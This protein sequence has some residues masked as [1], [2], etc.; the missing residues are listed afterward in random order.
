MRNLSITRT[1]C[2][3]ACLGKMKVYIEDP[4]LGDTVISG[5][6]CR[7]LGDLKNGETATFPI[8]EEAARVFVIADQMSR[9]Y[10]NDCYPLEAGTQ[11]VVLTGKNHF[12]PGAGNP[13]R[14]DGVSDEAILS[15]RKKGS[16]KGIL[17]LIIAAIVGFA[18]GKSRTHIV[19]PQDFTVDTMTITLT[20]SFRQAEI[21]GFTQCFE[22]PIVGV[23]ILKEEF[24][25]YPGLEDY[26]LSEYG[27]AVIRNNAL[28]DSTL[29]PYEDF[30]YFTYTSSGEDGTTYGYFATVHKSSDA[31][32]L[33]QFSTAADYFSSSE[34]QFLQ[35]A[36]SVRFD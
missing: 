10:S 23:A 2:F 17:V 30:M 31:F 21:E 18:I 28:S 9:N 22:S 14:F 20:N 13:F 11:D 8:G 24:S 34:N 3:V 19:R 32:W 7:K 5:V 15:A 26:T 16:R 36:G 1:K 33:I 27:D 12:N 25:Q 6:S 29:T 35:W 4:D